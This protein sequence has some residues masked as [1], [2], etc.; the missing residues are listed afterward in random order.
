MIGRA[1]DLWQE[2]SRIGCS[3][4]L[5]RVRQLLL[6]KSGLDVRLHPVRAA[7]HDE[8]ALKHWRRCKPAFFVARAPDVKSAHPVIGQEAAHGK[9]LAFRNWKA[10][11]GFPVNWRL[12]PINGREWPA[13]THSLRLLTQSLRDA[14]GDIKN[15]WEIGRFLHIMD[16]LR[17][18]D[19]ALFDALF[20]QIES[21]EI[22]NPVY[23][24]PHWI[25]E[26]EVAIR[27]CMFALLLYS[28]D[29]TDR[30][31]SLL[32]RQIATAAE[33]C[34]N[35]IEFS[36]RCINNNHMVAGALCLYMAGIILEKP[37][38]RTK[39]RALLSEALES[40]W[41]DD[42]GYIQPS[43]NYHRLTMSYLLWALRLAELHDDH[44]LVLA[45]R[46]RCEKSFYFLLA[47]MDESSGRLPNWGPNDGALFP[48][49][50]DCDY[51]DFRPLLTALRYA[52]SFSRAFE[53][54]P[55]DEPL[56]WL[57]GPPA[58]NAPCLISS[59]PQEAHF[60]SAGL[61][62]LRDP[63]QS[64]VFRAGPIL[65]R[66]GQQAD[67]M[68]IDYFRHGKNI[69]R[70]AGSFCYADQRFHEWF[71]STSAHNTVE[72]AGESQ[73][74]PHRQFL[75][76]DW[77]DVRALPLPLAQG[78]V[79]TWIAF[80]HD[81]YRRLPQNALHA[82]LL[83][84]LDNGS[85]LVIDRIIARQ[86]DAKPLNA[87]LSW[88]LAGRVNVSN[89]M[90]LSFGHDFGL[91]WWAPVGA[92]VNIEKSWLARG[93]GSKDETDC[94]AVTSAF[95]SD[96]LFISCFGASDSLPRALFYDAE[97]GLIHL[98]ETSIQLPE[99]FIRISHVFNHDA[100]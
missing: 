38:Y 78:R 30:Q 86:K 67:Q 56:L 53:P 73:M 17:A 70:D 6:K 9:I 7:A 100:T 99:N 24:G 48:A 39:G 25:S 27:A 58:L 5:F 49:W 12:N 95:T 64:V 85:F 4:A 71:R 87:I 19:A 55:W 41:H 60:P 10:D 91:C 21:F 47:F 14:T 89:H 97:T 43:H 93:Y 45:I 92:T 61:H 37:G 81:G 11:F 57:W 13:K 77:P 2:I 88:H 15:T 51:A 16:I 1:A 22:E 35:E 59:A 31:A 76:L 79:L 94:L 90:W 34:D 65:S 72:L 18:G 63:L 36:R 96:T 26:Q 46:H 28:H 23:E 66:F 74:R 32:L 3:A 8:Q 29:C 62:I 44:A 52:F 50:S 54:G 69:L 82:R 20:A 40:Q 42:G 98:D 68:H 80:A 84:K 75:F 83:A 33:Y